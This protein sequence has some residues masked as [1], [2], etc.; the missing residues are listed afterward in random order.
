M[1]SL[2]RF[3]VVIS[4][5]C[6]CCNKY[7]LNHLRQQEKESEEAHWVYNVKVKTS[8][9]RCGNRTWWE[10][11]ELYFLWFMA[12]LALYLYGFIYTLFVFLFACREY[13]KRYLLVYTFIQVPIPQNTVAVVERAIHASSVA[14]KGSAFRAHGTFVHHLSNMEADELTKQSLLAWAPICMLNFMFGRTGVSR[15]YAKGHPSVSAERRVDPPSETLTFKGNPDIE[16][17]AM[18]GT[19]LNGDEYGEEKRVKGGDSYADERILAR[20]IGPDLIPT[21]TFQS[22]KGNLKAGLAKRVKPLPFVPKKDM[23]RRI[24]RTVTAL[25]V[26]V[27][28]SQKIKKWREEN[29]D[30]FELHSKKWSAERF[31]RAFEEAL[32]DVSSKI[33]QEF[34]IK[35]NEALPAKGKAPRP[36][37]QT[38]DKG[39]VMMLLPVKCF[40]ELLFEYYEDAS[41]KHLPKHEAMQRVAQHLRLPEGNIVEGD[42]SA[43]DACCNAGIRGMTENRI[44][45]HI[46]EV[47][48]ED[49]QVPQGWMRNCLDDMKKNKIKGKAKVDNK[50]YVCPLK[51]QIEAI[52]QSGHRGTSAFNYLINLVGWLCVLCVE[53]AKMIRKKRYDG[54][55]KLPTWYC[56]IHDNNW[57]QLKYSFEGD[58]SGLCTTEK[59]NAEEVEIAWKT[60]GFRMKLK[61]ATDFFTFT[62]F[63]FLLKDG[64]PN[65]TFCPEIPRNI[66]S[67]SWTTSSE[68][69]A[70][71]ESINVIGAAAM[72]SR[73]ENFKDCGPMSRYFAELGLAHV[74]I[75]GDFGLDDSA[76]LKLGIYPVDSVKDR[77]HELS[78]SASVPS[79]DM[80]LLC[81]RTFGGFMREQ[82]ALLL[83]C[84]FDNPEAEEARYLI[85]AK[86]W[87]PDDFEQARR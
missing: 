19:Q 70:H 43:W 87:D 41:I 74:K 13:R 16:D 50:K 9:T 76:S 71:P 53:P 84:A 12:A 1:D 3:C 36:I 38:G 37:I 81:E 56:S 78:G 54:K 68:A 80:R 48:G 62:G 51:V 44:L 83:S 39:Q 77:L 27:F 63:D 65:G 28:P 14:E 15:S 64:I 4:E 22:T 75:S 35:V 42:G 11:M 72:L 57:Y 24:E 25:I 26:E 31:R 82:E 18:K 85:P 6:P 21:E 59:L 79:S 55:L 60:L 20:Q 61:Y 58:D 29:C 17:G 10:R 47:L 30:V 45:E 73:A 67:S 69:K 8:C 5:P 52:R 2:S 86:L 40:E 46:I 32:S 7:E 66:A 34:Q 49:S 23:I 33:E